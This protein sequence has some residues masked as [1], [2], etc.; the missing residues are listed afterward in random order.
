MTF[1]EMKFCVDVMVA[2]LSP[3]TGVVS[4]GWLRRWAEQDTKYTFLEEFLRINESFRLGIK[5]P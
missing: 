2:R 5:I 1:K 3:D 4:L